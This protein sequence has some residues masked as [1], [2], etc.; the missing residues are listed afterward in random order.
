VLAGFAVLILPLRIVQEANPDWRPFNWAHAAVVLGATFALVHQLG[1]ESWVRHFAC[2]FLLILFAIPWP[3][4][5]EQG[6]IQT[7]SRGVTFCTAETLDLT[8]IP[9]FQRGNLIEVATGFVSIDDAC[10][11][12]RSLAG[13]LMTGAFFGEFY[14]LSRWR[15]LGMI[16]IGGT[17]ALALNMVR[18]Y[19]LSWLQATGGS[20]RIIGGTIVPASRSL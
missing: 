3:L 1:G 7:L 18:A 19:I 5:A 4:A 9:A 8:G 14:R 10:S 13:A 11:G 20:K 2:P 12:I 6:V 17:V 15:R 16:A